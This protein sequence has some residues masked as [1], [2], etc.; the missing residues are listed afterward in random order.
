MLFPQPAIVT[1]IVHFKLK[2]PAKTN[3]KKN[4]VAKKNPSEPVAV[5]SK[6]KV[7]KQLAEK[8]TSKHEEKHPAEKK[9]SKHEEHHPAEK[10]SSK[11]EEHHPAE[12]KSS[13][14]VEQHPA[15]KTNRANKKRRLSENQP[16]HGQSSPPKHSLSAA[17]PREVKTVAPKKTT[18]RPHEQATRPREETPTVVPPVIHHPKPV[19]SNSA[20]QKRHAQRSDEVAVTPTPSKPGLFTLVGNGLTKVVKEVEHGAEIV[21]EEV[22]KIIEDPQAELKRAEEEARK[23]AKKGE[24]AVKRGVETVKRVVK[25]VKEAITNEGKIHPDT[26]DL[27]PPPSFVTRQSADS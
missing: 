8:K 5:T 11:H 4:P 19:P 15:E 24:E 17:Q 22:E 16:H 12:K 26:D 7:V 14:H 9:S 23:L 25:G 2:M 27:A 21:E 13:K 1:S 6:K 18:A 10:K 20:A 3:S